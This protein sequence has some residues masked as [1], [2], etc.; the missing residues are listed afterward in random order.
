MDYRASPFYKSIF[1]FGILNLDLN[2]PL[3]IL[4]LVLVVMF[5]LNKLLFTPVLTTLERRA[6]LLS[7]L[8]K[9]AEANKMEVERL[10]QSYEADLAKARAEVA[11]VRAQAHQEAARATEQILEQARKTGAEALERAMKELEQDV[12]RAKT[13]LAQAAQRLAAATATRVLNG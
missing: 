13:E 3:F 11:T 9:Q 10:T 6:T 12:A 8:A 5:C 1:D 2:T 4:V 7:D